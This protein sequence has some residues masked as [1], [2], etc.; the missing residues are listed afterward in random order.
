MNLWKTLR[1]RF[2]PAKP[3]PEG[4][5]PLRNKPGGL[6]WINSK[7]GDGDGSEVLVNRIVQTVRL[8]HSDM[9]QIEPPQE[10]TV[11]SPVFN[12]PSGKQ[13][14]AGD[15]VVSI[16][17]RDEC[18]T[19]IP[20]VGDDAR[21]ESLAWLPPVPTIVAGMEDLRAQ[22]GSGPFMVTGWRY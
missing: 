13:F 6:A 11:T 16:G 17:I 3:Q 2:S 4:P 22:T 14:L 12:V 15:R 7:V 18:L 21:D 5:P 8:R 19:P 10:Y 9:W 20:D 1:E